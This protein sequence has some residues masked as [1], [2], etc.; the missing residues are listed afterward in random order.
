MA[1][2]N[3]SG[4]G[5]FGYNQRFAGQYF[6]KETGLHYNV[7]RDYNPAIG[8]YVQSDPIGLAGGIN[9]YAYVRGNPISLVDPT[10]ENGLIAA[11]IT[12]AVFAYGAY[13]GWESFA[14]IQNAVN[15]GNQA[16]ANAATNE[17]SPSAAMT[18]TRTQAAPPIGNI[19]FRG[20]TVIFIGRY[21][22]NTPVGAMGFVAGFGAAAACKS[23][24]NK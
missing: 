15:Q 10:G 4:L 20:V 19:G 11:A 16:A 24:H 17:V 2:E 9:T 7:N 14:T 3:P 1:N 13:Q 21:T 6:D 12:G 18:G 5:T 8:G 22:G 23:T